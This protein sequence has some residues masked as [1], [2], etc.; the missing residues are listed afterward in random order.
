MIIMSRA[1]HE[2]LRRDMEDYKLLLTK[3]QTLRIEQEILISDLERQG[4][5]LANKNDIL[6]EFRKKNEELLKQIDVLNAK[7]EKQ[8]AEIG[9]LHEDYNRV[10]RNLYN[11]KGK[12]IRMRKDQTEV[13]L[14]RGAAVFFFVSMLIVAAH[15]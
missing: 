13:Y 2:A 4:Q 5:L 6:I 8:K 15:G 7:V 1:K 14:W 10:N 12:V 9:G 3:Y 11:E